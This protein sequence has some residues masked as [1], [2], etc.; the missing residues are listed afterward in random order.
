MLK[1]IL[2]YVLVGA[3]ALLYPARLTAQVKSEAQILN[4]AYDPT[5]LAL[6]GNAGTNPNPNNCLAHPGFLSA[7]QILNCVYDPIGHGLYFSGMAGA[8]MTIGGAVAGGTQ[9]SILYIDTSGNLAQDN[10]YF[11]WRDSDH[12]LTAA[13]VAGNAT[14]STG[15]YGGAFNVPPLPVPINLGFTI[16]GGGTL[17][18]GTYCYR[19]TALNI[20]GETTP[21]TETCI[22]ATSGSS[23]EVYVF[24]GRFLNA[25]SCKVYGRT[26]GAEQFLHAGMLVGEVCVY[27]DTGADTPSGSMPGANT[28]A[29]FTVDST[30]GVTASGTSCTITA[31]KGGLI[32]AATCI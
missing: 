6:R 9:A 8:S 24:A 21:S 17:G 16:G 4:A 3:A 26:S 25:A 14:S 20:F 13:N 10:A 23:N 2:L 29:G 11:S 27:T 15:G 32:T 30:P 19:I 5:A 1:R 18:V 12:T 7:A 31:I 22:N 28:T